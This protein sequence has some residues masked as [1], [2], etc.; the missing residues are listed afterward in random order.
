MDVI[1]DVSGYGLRKLFKNIYSNVVTN[2]KLELGQK[3]LS[4]GWKTCMGISMLFNVPF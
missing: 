1:F 4:Y 2:W 3:N